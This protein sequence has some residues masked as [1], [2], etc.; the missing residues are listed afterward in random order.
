MFWIDFERDMERNLVK[1]ELDSYRF[2]R[3]RG[4]FSNILF[5]TTATGTGFSEEKAK[6]ESFDSCKER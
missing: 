5:I 1:Y 6:L 4:I 2:E 3:M